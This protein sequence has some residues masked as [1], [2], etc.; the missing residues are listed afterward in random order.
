M[1]NSFVLLIKPRVRLTRPY[2]LL[3]LIVLTTSSVFA[4]DKKT[5]VS[6]EADM[7][8]LSA[9][10]IKDGNYQRALTTLANFQV[11]EET[12]PEDLIRYHTLLGLAEL[13]MQQF[14]LAQKD[15]YQA[16]KFG[17]ADPVIYIYLAQAHYSLNEYEPTITSIDKAGDII[18]NYPALLEIKAQ[19]QWLL[20]RK[21]NS[22]NTLNQARVMFP[23]DYRFLRR[24]VFYL[25]DLGFY[26]RAAELGKDYLSLSNATAE[27]YLAIGNALR[28]SHQF[29]Q[30]TTILEKARLLFQ[31]NPT[32]AKVL[33]HTYLDMDL[34]G[35]A[36]SILEQASYFENKLVS[37]S[38]ELYRRAGQLNRAMLLNARIKDQKIKLKQRVAI[39]VG[40]KNYEN[41]A[42]MESD[43]KRVGLMDDQ[44]II[45]ALAYAQFASGQFSGI[46]PLLNRLTEPELFKKATELRR[47]IQE[48][49]E[50]PTNCV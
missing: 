36:A 9:M 13:N 23:D 31:D 24:Q 5:D 21:E 18:K 34:P 35:T 41:V 38:A 40:M 27:D 28:L 8:T 49:Q 20:G 33:A 19:S 4:A 3:I 2:V 37:E 11:V 16:I 46:E 22:W 25:V 15:F 45:Y 14:K 12:P 39:L 1:M 26:R 42:Q 48:C 32:V 47:A 17:Q 43:L 29:D 7:L 50:Q 10:L 44:P 30:A 6:I